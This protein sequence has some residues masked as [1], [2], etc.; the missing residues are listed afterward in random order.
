MKLI[1]YYV[2]KSYSLTKNCF[3]T[4]FRTFILISANDKVK[5]FNVEQRPHGTGLTMKKEKLLTIK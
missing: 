1:F 3:Y 2:Q 4:I 5:S